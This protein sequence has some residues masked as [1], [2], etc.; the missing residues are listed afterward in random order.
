[1]SHVSKRC[2]TTPESVY[3][4]MSKAT[5]RRHERQ[6]KEKDR[7]IGIL[8]PA[9]KGSFCYSKKKDPLILVLDWS[10]LRLFQRLQ[11]VL[12]YVNLDKYVSINLE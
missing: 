1:M 12:I 9:G 2:Q 8:V 11:Y 4:P 10:T 7:S 3:V 6:E 5:H